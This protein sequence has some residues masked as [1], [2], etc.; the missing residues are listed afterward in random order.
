MNTTTT[1]PTE[2]V[3]V[4]CA[5]D[6]GN[7]VQLEHIKQCPQCRDY[8]EE[9]RSVYKDISSIDEEPVPERLAAKILAI[10]RSKRPQNFVWNFLQTWYKN[11]FLIG[12][13]TVGAIL[14]L[15]GLMHLCMQ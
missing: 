1:H 10:S 6:K 15:Y 4:E 13:V 8:V 9:I 11:P 12:I 7:E 3:L 14:L 2:E 5:L